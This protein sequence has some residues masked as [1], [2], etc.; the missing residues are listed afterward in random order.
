MTRS[1]RLVPL[2]AIVAALGAVG[3]E[4]RPAATPFRPGDARASGSVTAGVSPAIAAGTAPA[5][6]PR[7][8]GFGGV[9]VERSFRLP[10]GATPDAPFTWRLLVVLVEF[11][12]V[13]GDRSPESVH[14]ALFDDAAPGLTSYWLGVSGG[15]MRVEGTVTRWIRLPE[16]YAYYTN[17]GAGNAG[18]G[19]D[20]NAYPN[21]AQRLVEEA[22]AALGSGYDGARFDNTGDGLVD[23]LLVLHAGPGLEEGV[24][25]AGGDPRLTLLAHQFHVKEPAALRDTPV[26]DYALAA[27]SAGHGVLAHEMGHLLGLLDL[28]DTSLFAGASGPFGLGDWSLMATGALL[29]EGRTPAGLDAD[30]RVRLGFA[31]PIDVAFG[32]A[33][34]D[35]LFGPGDRRIYRLPSGVDPKQHFLVELRSR[36]GVDA[37][38]PGNGLLIYH[39]D[40]SRQSNSSNT[41]YRVAL[42]QADGRNDLGR[43]GGNRGDAGDAWP[44]SGDGPATFDD[45]SSPSSRTYEGASS[46]ASVADIHRTGAGVGARLALH[47]PFR[48]TLSGL[49]VREAPGGDGD[50]AIDA[51][52][53]ALVDLTLC[54]AGVEETGPLDVVV[55]ALPATADVVGWDLSA[56]ESLPSLPAGSC[57]RAAPLFSFDVVP[58]AAPPEAIAL[59]LLLTGEGRDFTQD[60]LLPLRPGAGV[61]LS[62]AAGEA[63]FTARRLAGAV[64]DW[65]VDASRFRSAPAAWR[66]GP[67]SGAAYPVGLDAVYESP[68]F[69][70][71]ES[72]P[73]LALWSAIEAESLTAGRAWDGGRVE[74]Q[75]DTEAWMPLEPAGGWTHRLE[76]GSGNPLHGEAVVSGHADAFTRFVFDLAPWGGR[77]ARVRFR[78]ASDLFTAPDQ[79]QRGWWIDDL[80]V[81]SGSPPPVMEAIALGDS[82]RVLVVPPG[83]V[84]GSWRVERRAPGEDAV[85][86]TLVPASPI[87]PRPG[88]VFE[89][90]SRPP[91]GTWIYSVRPIE[92]EGPGLETS[93]EPVVVTRSAPKTAIALFSNPYR[94]DGPPLTVEYSVPGETG[95]A[96]VPARAELFDA[97][98]RLVARLLDEPLSP[99]VTSRT[100]TPGAMNRTLAPGVYFVRF[101]AGKGAGASARLVV[102]R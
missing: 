13:R 56:G 24:P 52:E 51:G 8:A 27:A 69:V 83:G 32:S 23:G 92:A 44:G 60:L 98:G 20:P 7:P 65:E 35:I 4:V 10:E 46:F 61:T 41:R 45:A 34:L 70:V 67:V 5:P 58:G 25:P 17:E 81:E 86:T 53:T 64:G 40:E 36:S 50:G 71:P 94:L 62:A 82:V 3:G 68:L 2:A 73:R 63:T 12:D 90:V 54:N 43:V 80:R 18:S 74:I 22:V 101:V 57:R 39:V 29:G 48:L 37:A 66:L 42:E 1:A 93:S 76:T 100:W 55:S 72:H 77:A 38:L 14:A 9:P 102:T 15:R 95:A 47:P 16:T 99:G 28:Y 88:D 89:I 96:K 19:I 91:P 6:A 21:N 85:R 11:A 59:R 49:E 87:P 75:A 31:T 97:A 84:T 78:F 79:S 30:S 26:F 33:P